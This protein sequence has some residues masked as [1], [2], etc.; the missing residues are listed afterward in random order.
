MSHSFPTVSHR[1][2]LSHIH[3]GT[4]LG[5][6][7]LGLSAWGEKNMLNISVGCSELW[8]HRG[9]MVWTARQNYPDIRAA[10]EAHDGERIRAL[11]RPDTESVP[12]MPMRPSIIP[13]G[14]IA[15]ELDDELDRVD[16]I[17]E[18]GLVRV[19]FK[20]TAEPLELRLSMSDKGAFAFRFSRIKSVRAVPSY[21]LA[22]V[23]KE[24]SFAEPTR[25]AN[26]FVQPMPADPSCSLLFERSG[27]TV[28]CRFRRGENPAPA[29]VAPW[30]E[31][32]AENTAYWK[33]FWASVPSMRC[34][35]PV[36]ELC[37][38]LGLFKFQSMTA[39]DGVPAGLQGPWI[40]DHRL[41]PW[42]GDYHFNINVQMC[43]WPAY[44]AGLCEN[45]KPLFRMIRSWRDV[46][47]RNA[48]YFVG[49]DNGYMMPHAVDDRC[50]CMGSFWSGTIDHACSAWMAQMM[51]EYYD[52]T[53]EEEFLRDFAFDFMSGV[54]NVYLAML[55][56]RDGKLT[57]PVSVSPEYRGAAMN[58]WG[59]DPSFQL[60]A[61][62]RLANDLIRVA[63]ILGE[64]V[65]PAWERVREKLPEATLIEL[66]GKKQIALWE[67]VPLEE[68]H[69]HHSHLAG[70]C[71]FATI[72]PGDP[73]WE[74]VLGNSFRHWMQM[75]MG[76]WAGWS[77]PW[78]AMLHNRFGN[79]EMS[80]AVIEIWHRT[81]VNK[82]GG[83]LHDPL[84]PGFS[85]GLDVSSE[86]MQMDA[87]MGIVAAIQDLFVYALDNELYLMSGCVES[88]REV[89][90][91]RLRCPGG[92][93]ADLHRG[94]VE[95][96]VIRLRATRPNRLAVHLPDS[97]RGWTADGVPFAGN[98]LNR[99]MKAG[100]TI[101]LQTCR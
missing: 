75:G 56:E 19:F 67:G 25:L 85:S 95:G 68:S 94:E 35:N 74:T 98:T 82:G 23:L 50:V 70:I 5:N 97:P 38:S 24:I 45:L 13:L 30:S 49:I 60:A 6:G 100:E 66:D 21:D 34:G 54:M 72:R 41:P 89:A 73:Q 28:F 12:G 39:P 93:V 59:A 53:G 2:P 40:E 48:K 62:H 52:Y 20:H 84:F 51:C 11:F 80:E 71:P 58:A 36:L 79:A 46:L 18:S 61:V 90:V 9:G 10:L 81:F 86:V 1:F 78:A 32:E 83:T 4:T 22:P 3:Q 16:L 55:E 63:G 92:F 47:R 91:S 101:V 29:G 43:Y 27:E 96:T 8:D 69:R 88:W 42:S 76:C 99:D 15:V 31:L 26:G 77:M 33:R 14:R 7:Y 64:P 57:L 17:L 44:R 37:Y 65:D 87:C